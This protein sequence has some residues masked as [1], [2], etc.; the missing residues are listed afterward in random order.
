MTIIAEAPHL[1]M[2]RTIHPHVTSLVMWAML[3]N[4]V[5]GSGL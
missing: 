5:F 3:P 2:P 1:C 4:A